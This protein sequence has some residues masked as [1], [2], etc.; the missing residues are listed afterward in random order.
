[1]A[2]P[3]IQ[4][5]T[6]FEP[7][8]R[9][10]SFGNVLVR[11]EVAGFRLHKQTVVE[12]RS[13]ITA[14]CGPNGTGKTTLLQLAA[15]AYQDADATKSYT[16]PEFF[17]MGP[18]DP[19]PFEPQAQLAITAWQTDANKARSYTL[20]RRP[21]S[22]WSDY[23]KRE[24]R[25]VL[26]LGAGDFLPRAEQQDFSFRHAARLTISDQT[27]CA[28]EVSKAV[29]QIL[30]T[31]YDAI[32][33]AK[34]Q[35]KDRSGSILSSSRGSLRYS[36]HHM[37]FGECRVHN[38][39]ETLEAQT[40]KSLILLEEPE[41][42]LHQAAQHRL[43]HYL[44][45]LATRKGHQILISTHSEHLLRSLPEASR[46]LLVRDAK[47]AVQS[48]PG[49]ASAQAASIMTD[50]YDKALTAV[51]ED[52]VATSVLA[53]ILAFKNPH[54][55]GATRIIIGGC[56][57]DKGRTAGGKDAITAA[58]KTLTESGLRVAAVLDGDARADPQSYVFRLPGSK[59]PEPEIF[60]STA[61]QNFWLNEYQLDTAALIAELADVNHHDWFD[62]LSH[63]VNR[64]REFLVGEAARVYARSLGTATDELVAQLK[65]AAS[66][67]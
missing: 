23:R 21:S 60:Q 25:S 27:K 41:I 51:V 67:P 59:P 35:L 7:T 24:Y 64:S 66:K 29:T 12:F 34:V 13:P 55:L 42:S 36:E 9:F 14:F 32:E 3:R 16:F 5:R 63:R 58:M 40:P 47:G 6:R 44:I 22:R 52:D 57:N 18:L 30:N 65:D 20:S 50:G 28:V 4:L 37:G 15:C 56:P 62:R 2:D 39:V 48:L 46:V 26:F 53:E 31:P 1:V 49:L 61:V 54:L 19:A 8:S 43:G 11:L 38:L 17:A 45:S 33:R 10:A